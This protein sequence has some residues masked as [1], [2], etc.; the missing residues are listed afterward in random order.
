M[1]YKTL[2]EL[3]LQLV[4]SKSIT[5]TKGTPDWVRADVR[6]Y[7]DGSTPDFALVLAFDL[8]K[9]QDAERLSSTIGIIK[10]LNLAY[11]YSAGNKVAQVA[12]K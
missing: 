5:E 10:S 8:T 3:G 9:Q 1:N 12:V 4:K 7:E 6:L 2:C 11:T